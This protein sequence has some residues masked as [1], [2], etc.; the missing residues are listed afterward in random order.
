MLFIVLI[1]LSINAVAS[2]I[3]PSPIL[4]LLANDGGSND[5]AGLPYIK[6]ALAFQGNLLPLGNNNN[7][8]FYQHSYPPTATPTPASTIANQQIGGWMGRCLSAAATA[9]APLLT[10]KLGTTTNPPFSV[11]PRNVVASD[12]YCNIQ[13]PQSYLNQNN[14]MNLFLQCLPTTQSRNFFASINNNFGSAPYC[15]SVIGTTL[16]PPLIERQEQQ[17]ANE[18]IDQST[19]SNIQCIN[20]QCQTSSSGTTGEP[21]GSN[22]SQQTTC[23]NNV[24]QTTTC[25]N[26]QCQTSS[27][28]GTATTTIGRQGREVDQ[29]QNVI[30][31]Q[32]VNQQASCAFSPRIITLGCI[33]NPTSVHTINEGSNEMFTPHSNIPF[34]LPFP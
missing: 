33:N 20:G 14:K 24:C 2:T 3:Q 23:I 16:L 25:I 29:G 11:L 32:R 6:P 28:S 26:G 21:A 5:H 10:A 34:L 9:T 17:Q 18:A 7:N 30:V 19:G 27:S 22:V 12:P 1:S 8:Y 13:Y 31:Q 4:K 15:N